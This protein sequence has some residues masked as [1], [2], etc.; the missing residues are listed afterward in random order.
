MKLFP[1][2]EVFR[3]SPGVFLMEHQRSEEQAMGW[4]TGAMSLSLKNEGRI[5][6]ANSFLSN[7]A[8]NWP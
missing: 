6:F 8:A 1:S 7:L 4:R 2:R 5:C 3:G